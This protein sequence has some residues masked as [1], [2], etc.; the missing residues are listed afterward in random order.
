MGTQVEILG[1]STVLRGHQ[2]LPPTGA[3]Y[4]EHWDYT[5]GMAVANLV[6]HTDVSTDGD[7]SGG[8]EGLY[9]V[10]M[11]HSWMGTP[12]EVLGDCKGFL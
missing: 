12:L 2:L 1:G 11:M 4:R 3:L 5:F 6:A 9:G 8:P 10:L 7:T